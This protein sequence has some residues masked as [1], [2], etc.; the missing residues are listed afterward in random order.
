LKTDVNL[1]TIRNKPKKTYVPLKDY[2]TP[3]VSSSSPGDLPALQ[4]VNFL[5]I[6]LLYCPFGLYLNLYCRVGKNNVML[7]CVPN[8]PVDPKADAAAPVSMLFRYIC[9][10]PSDTFFPP[11]TVLDLLIERE[12][13]QITVCKHGLVVK[14]KIVI[15]VFLNNVEKSLLLKFLF[16]CSFRVLKGTVSRDWVVPCIVLMDRP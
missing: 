1:H 9:T 6:T 11:I 2:Q 16:I 10:S 15:H 5:N 7:I 4:T 3:G 14:Y 13:S 8:P 12:K